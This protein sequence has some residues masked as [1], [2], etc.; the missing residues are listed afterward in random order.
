MM[1][2]PIDIADFAFRDAARVREWF[3]ADLGP[4]TYVEVEGMG[5]TVWID[6]A[7]VYEYW[8]ENTTPSRV[9][10]ASPTQHQAV[11]AAATTALGDWVRETG[12]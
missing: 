12:L 2:L 1:E 3:D 9:A 7:Q 6:F 11:E 8:E 10:K 4:E 5:Y